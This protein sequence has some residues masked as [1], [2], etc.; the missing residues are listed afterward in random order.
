[1]PDKPQAVFLCS[2]RTTVQR[3]SFEIGLLSSI[4]TVSPGLN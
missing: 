1:M 3:F 4:H 2:P